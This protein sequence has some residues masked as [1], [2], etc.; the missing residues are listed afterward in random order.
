MKDLPP[1]GFRP[2]GRFVTNMNTPH[3]RQIA[4]ARRVWRRHVS[5]VGS[6]LL[7]A[8]LVPP[9]GL[10]AQSNYATPYAF[11][12]LAGDAGFGATDG[13]GSAGRFYYPAGIAADDAGNLYVADT[14]NHTIR[15]IT[16]GGVVTTLA[17]TAGSPGSS[18]GT[19]SAARFNF[20]QSVAVDSA[21]NV[22]VADRGNHT[23]RNITSC[24]VVATLA[25]TA[26]TPGSAD[27][28]GSSAQFN[29]PY[30][31][32]VDG[33][34]YL[35][36]ADTNNHTIRKITGDG[37]VA[38]MAGTAGGSGSVD[39][40]GSAARFY[41]PHG[42]AVD[43]GGN[44]YVAD[45][46][47]FTVRKVT[48]A[49]AVTT[50]A[51]AT[52]VQGSLDG[53]GS[54]A[55]FRLPF[56]VAVDGAGNVYV[57][58]RDN[59]AIREIS[60]GGVV[61]T[62]AGTAS[63]FSSGSA[64]G[65]GSAAQFY[66]PEGVATDNAG[67]VYVA[68][69]SNHMVRKIT[70][71]GVVTTL[72]G[73][74]HRQI[75]VDG[76]GSAAQF[77]E[78]FGVA[79]DG[80]GNVY[81]GDT[82]NRTI[83]KIA[84]G[85]VVTT[86]AG[87]PGVSGSLDG[88]GS[89]AQFANPYGMAVD[90]S[91]NIYVADRD[92]QTIRKVTSG[93][94]VTTLA[95]SPG[96]PG[97]ID[98]TGSAALFWLPIGVAV[99]SAGNVYVADTI[100][101]AIRKITPD[102]V[103]TTLAGM[104]GISGSADGTA[105]AARFSS[106]QGVAVDGAGNVYVADTNNNAIRKITSEGI[107]TTLAGMAGSE[108]AADGTGSAA[109]F[110]G[111]QGVAVDGG[112]NVY[113][114]DS[115]N[116]LIRKISAGG[117][118]TTLGGSP[119]IHGTTDGTGDAARFYEPSGV[120]VDNAGN[121]YVADYYN[122]TV[123]VGIPVVIP[124]TNSVQPPSVAI[125]AGQG[126]LFTVTVNGTAPF[127]YQWQMQALGS[128]SWVN[129]SDAGEFSGTATA[130][131]A[132]TAATGDLNGAR[133]QCVVTNSAGSAVSNPAVL[134]VSYLAGVA[135]QSGNETVIAGQG[136]SFSVGVEAE[137]IPAYQWQVSTDGGSNWTNLTD[138]SG[139][140]GSTTATLAIDATT[141]IMTG[142]QFKLTATNG[143]GSVT[144]TPMT[145]TVTPLAEGEVVG[146]DF[147]TLAGT[148]GQGGSTDG[149]GSAAKFSHPT[150]LAVDSAGNVYVA[151]NVNSTIRMIAP[152]GVVTTIAGSAGNR[153]S[154]DGTGTAAQFNYPAGVAVDGVGVL[155]VADTHNHLIRRIAPKVVTGVTTWVVTTL[156]G[157]AGSAGSADGMGSAAQFA[158]PEGVAVDAAGN[159][160]VADSGNNLIREITPTGVVITLAG[161]AGSTGSADGTGSLARFTYPTGVAVDRAGSLY[162]ADSN[163]DMIR[164]IVPTDV[165]GSTAWTVTTLAGTAGTFQAGGSADG[166]GSA[167]GFFIP[168]GLA[169][170][171]S[172][173]VFVADTLNFTIRRISPAGLVTTLAGAVHS[174]GSAD[175]AG[176]DARFGYPSRIAVDGSGNLYVADLGT[177]TI[178]V[179]I[180]TAMAPATISGQ[181]QGT[182]VNAGQNTTFHV[183]A[184]GTPTFT[185]QWQLQSPGSTDWTDLA[186]SG[187]FSGT[188]TA[189]L[190]ITGATEDLNGA[191][192]R[193]VIGNASGS[194]ASDPATLV[195][196]FHSGDFGGNG[197]SDLIWSNTATGDR[198][199]WLMNGTSV[200][201][202]IY[203]GNIAPQWSAV[204][205]NFNANAST[206]LLWSDTVTG[207]RYIWL[208]NGT[209]V[210]SSVYL[211][212][213]APQW[214]VTTGDFNGDG[215][216]DLL[217]S[218]M[219][220]GDRY[221]WLMNG[222]SFNA[223]VYLGKLDPNWLAAATGD[224]DGDG[225]TDIVWQS[226][227]TG[228]CSV[229]LMN[230]TQ[231]TG[232]ALLGTVS[233]QLRIAMVGDFN[234][235]GRPD[236]VWQNVVTGD[237][238]V[239]L[240]N[241]TTLSA[242]VFLGN[243]GT[244]WSIGPNV[245]AAP[246][247]HVAS[248]FNGDGR[249]DILWTNTASGDRYLWLMNA[250]AIVSSV[251]LGNVAPQWAVTAGVFGGQ[252]QADLLWSNTINGDHYIWL[253]NGAA[254]GSSV[255]LGTVAPE[256]TVTAGNFH[257]DGQTDLLW[258]N[259]IN[260]DRYIWLMNGTSIMSSVYLG[261]VA[262]QWA[263]ATGDFNSDGQADL[264]WSNTIN[265]DR[266]IWLMSGTSVTSSVYLGHVAP[267]WTVTTG[268]YNGDGRSDLLWSNMSNGD[269]YLW[270]M[271]GTSVSSSVYLSN[272][273]VQWSTGN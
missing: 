3:F 233:T 268:D 114:A 118:V 79:V 41:F 142:Y 162:V 54:A 104:F 211:G 2:A 135:L 250:A 128:E 146:Y 115:N 138:G 239:W 235:D 185:Y 87:S 95:G 175:G 228:V 86:L 113:V 48:S 137:P 249:S 208:M 24:G 240:M 169:V 197:Q 165:N 237:R 212:N 58:D 98:G 222:A 172:G 194:A 35:Y 218:D 230:G 64:D 220:T 82:N 221:I 124:P 126:A 209:S 4:R 112:G 260:G 265:G 75:A 267:D 16:S 170:D 80:A 255:F 256:W 105:G 188:A 163:D 187:Q 96:N 12:T 102:G 149:T 145:L 154:A 51:G 103:V 139:I 88:T 210:S 18:D 248:D 116:H 270:L 140:S 6:G 68:D 202:S 181:P 62:L 246:A 195:I 186:D 214:T 57:A 272:V 69:Q 254:F 10:Q 244:Q 251:Y 37:L 27:G 109:Q 129:L 77:N 107:V 63:F 70:S 206:D 226:T 31:V 61:T 9:G 125:N 46:N 40:T 131:L 184:T 179:G 155:I 21:G 207:D 66:F 141:A 71:G 171:G 17:G 5:V 173:N 147:S 97:R 84:S 73:K 241:G 238:S 160:Y 7:L 89:A 30:G 65:T 229:W 259:T 183:T 32:A 144:S 127:T 13:T 44:V 53:T 8:T 215:Q 157:T 15:K 258:S 29:T 132:I 25:G 174:A 263:V 93:G 164:K 74:P 182:A 167:A 176:R 120:A 227:A 121:V 261:N 133:F 156:A 243:V 14:D 28:P 264:L 90:S 152:T 231:Q 43:S 106:P 60:S 119:G 252:D 196:F 110:S 273:G 232:E 39:D 23:I 83:R 92:N 234:G 100:N 151:D 189:A 56:G 148:P 123:R 192:F 205:G 94:V 247:T 224:F 36:V 199:I 55:Q 213:V 76:A 81:V 59:Q 130:T 178:R 191:R 50:L 49:G 52:G 177:E 203:L 262:P 269:R 201:S 42:V 1:A 85:G 198:Y 153:G 200:V 108:G 216:S 190:Q 111:P 19:G 253:M 101:S 67:N 33:A 22:Y 45:Y 271:D 47:N 161:T 217:W 99:D 78:P 219:T 204:T 158:F 245:V 11:T 20:P 223:S 143:A 257:G 136:V 242:A 159:I 72:A 166:M 180:P 26:G 117:V 236:V 91:G 225:Q 168:E 134:T 38:T 34:G 193:C 122:Y 266:Y 150:G